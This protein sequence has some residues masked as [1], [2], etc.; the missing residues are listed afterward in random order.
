M[1]QP[2][3]SSALN[4]GGNTGACDGTFNF[5]FSQALMSSYGL[6]TGT[7]VYAQYIYSDPAHPDG[8]GYGYTDAIAFTLC[9]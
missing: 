5:H 6:T 8:S 4:S 9:P 1:L 7:S 2:E 3:M